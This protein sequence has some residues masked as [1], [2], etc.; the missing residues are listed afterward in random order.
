MRRPELLL[1]ALAVAAT[2]S[3]ACSRTDTPVAAEPTSRLDS[4]L[5]ALGNPNESARIA[6]ASEIR[7]LGTNALPYLVGVIGDGGNPGQ[8]KNRGNAVRA[9]DALGESAT[10]AIPQLQALLGAQKDPYYAAQ[11]LAGI[12]APGVPAL[13][14]GVASTNLKTQLACLTALESLRASSASA[15]PTLL[16]ATT[17]EAPTVRSAAATAIG[18]IG[19]S[20]EQSI[21]GLLPLLSDVE[22]SVRRTAAA[23][24]G[25]FGPRA[26]NTAKLIIPLLQD[27]DNSVRVSAA[28]ALWKVAAEEAKR[29]GV[30]NPAG[31]VTVR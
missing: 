27:P 24:L 14:T 10:P 21:P 12:G 17:H 26:G 3:L 20:P 18:S 11:S 6:A 30:S 22:P 5:A 13:L 4:V 29:L 31:A 25:S 1:C 8:R 16:A 15:V 23:A 28:G 19:A 2:F 7:G 9:F